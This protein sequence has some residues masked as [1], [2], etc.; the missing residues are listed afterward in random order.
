MDCLAFAAAFAYSPVMVYKSM[1]AYNYRPDYYKTVNARF[2]QFLTDEQKQAT[3]LYYS[4]KII[5]S[6]AKPV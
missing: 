6:I 3:H 1:R 5:R 4:S 2:V